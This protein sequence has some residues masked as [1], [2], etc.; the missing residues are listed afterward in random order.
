MLYKFS[1]PIEISASPLAP[2]ITDSQ[3]MCQNLNV[4]FLNGYRSSDFAFAVHNQDASTITSGLLNYQRVGGT[5]TPATGIVLTLD[6]AMQAWRRLNATDLQNVSVYGAGFLQQLDAATAR[7]YINAAQ[8]GHT[9]SAN[10]V[11]RDVFK[12]SRLGANPSTASHALVGNVNPN[13]NPQWKKLSY[14][15]IE[16]GVGVG[17]PPTTTGRLA[18]WSGTNALA[19][20]PV[21]SSGGFVQVLSGQGLA[22]ADDSFYI[23][24]VKMPKAPSSGLLYGLRANGGGATAWEEISTGDGDPPAAPESDGI[25]VLV[26][27]GGVASWVELTGDGVGIN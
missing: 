25:Y 4:E 15:D 5:A 8:A 13:G 26:V 10:D 17:L 18:M 19:D 21:L 24:G 3:V 14:A 20:S 27:S 16:S 22:V 23:N 2:I 12:V 9:H 7:A 6:S 11:D 1:Y